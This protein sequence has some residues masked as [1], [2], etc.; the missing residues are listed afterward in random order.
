M[1]NILS[2]AGMAAAAVV[3]FQTTCAAQTV[4]VDESKWWTVSAALRGFYDD[5]YLTSPKGGERDSLGFEVRP[6]VDVGHKGEQYIVK[7]SLLYSGRWFEDRDDE[8]WDHTFIADL[9]GEYQLNPSH[10]LRLNET[11]TYTS[12]GTLLDQGGPI[13]SP[14][15]SDGS[16]IRNVVDG[17]YVGQLNSLIGLELGYQNTWYSYEEDGPG[18]YG[19]LL[20]RLEHLFRAET[21]WTLTPTLAGILGYWYEDVNFTGDQ[22]IAPGL[23][24]DARDSYSHYIVGGADYTVSPNCFVSLRGGAQNVHYDNLVPKED[25]WNPFADV[26][27]T[28]EYLEG[29]YFR[30]GAKYGRNR[31]DVV[32]ALDQEAVTFYGLVNHKLTESLTA[33]ASG[34]IQMGE[35]SGGASDGVDENLYVAGISL[36]YDINRY[37]AVETGYNYDRLDSDFASR[38]FT[39]NRVFLGLRGQF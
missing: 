31:T 4:T 27:T 23:M 29:S 28:F 25:D 38:T 7:L 26:S 6:G 1:K 32:T 20:D 30:A 17:R 11:F 18:S 9:A 12:E 36:S 10:V 39:R 21:R 3:G 34:Q 19:A 33:R 35:F 24:S 8:E 15:R 37:L 16:N 2:S 5:N 22:L 13:T 14:L